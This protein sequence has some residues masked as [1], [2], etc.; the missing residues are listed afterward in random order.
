MDYAE[1]KRYEETCRKSIE[2]SKK[3]TE[4]ICKNYNDGVEKLQ[5]QL[6]LCMISSEEYHQNVERERDHMRYSFK[7]DCV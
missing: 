2:M 3:T 5:I 4:Q 6:R 7:F 1:R